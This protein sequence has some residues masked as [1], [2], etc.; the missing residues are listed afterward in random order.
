MGQS[1]DQT[2]WRALAAVLAAN[3]SQ[4]RKLLRLH[5]DAGCGRCRVCTRAGYGTPGATWPCTV[6][7]LATLAERVHEA[8]RRSG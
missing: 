3:P 5:V 1:S 6:H 8:H 4:F 2:L 7:Q